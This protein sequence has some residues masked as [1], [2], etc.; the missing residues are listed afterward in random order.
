MVFTAGFYDFDCDIY[1]R[2][3]NDGSDNICNL[4]Y[5]MPVHLSADVIMRLFFWF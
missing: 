1:S 5:F 3:N 2:S 4:F